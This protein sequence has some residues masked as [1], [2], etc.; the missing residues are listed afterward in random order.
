MFFN[1]EDKEIFASQIFNFD[2]TEPYCMDACICL[3]AAYTK[4]DYKNNKMWEINIQ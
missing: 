3:L 1:A 2:C 4:L